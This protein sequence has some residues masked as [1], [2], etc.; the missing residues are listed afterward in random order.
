M[1]EKLG[2]KGDFEMNILEDKWEEVLTTVK[3]EHELSQIS[4]DTWLKPLTI[5]KYDKEGNKT[6]ILV[7]Q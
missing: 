1:V 3:I 5:L 6:C 7:P 4:F 2:S